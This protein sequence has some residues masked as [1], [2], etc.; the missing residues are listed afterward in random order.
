MR[1]TPISKEAKHSLNRAE[2]SEAAQRVLARQGY[3][4]SSLR[5]IAVEAGVSLG[6]MHYYFT[7]KMHLMVSVFRDHQTRFIQNIHQIAA[8][9]GR[10]S[11]RCRQMAALWSREMR[12]RGKGYRIWYDLRNQAL[13]DLELRPVVSEMEH[14]QVAAVAALVG[15]EGSDADLIDRIRSQYV[16]LLGGLFHYALQR[17][18]FDEDLDFEQL[19][20]SFA[21]LLQ[22]ILDEVE[23]EG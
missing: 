1:D 14:L 21:S 11:E 5:D 10:P 18:I 23:A 3:A 19:E 17:T 22:Q 6:R 16:P 12:E 15:A 4:K 20:Q 8:T 7:D 9:G 13:F 2:L